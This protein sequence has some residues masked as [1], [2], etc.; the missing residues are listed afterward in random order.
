MQNG[1]LLKT[2]LV[3]VAAMVTACVLFVGTFSLIAVLVT[4]RVVGTQATS[5]EAI[6]AK[7]PAAKS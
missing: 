4:N 5:T 1:S 3:T 7:T 6:L 2:T